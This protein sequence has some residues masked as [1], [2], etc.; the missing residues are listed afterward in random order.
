MRLAREFSSVDVTCLM[1]LTN[2]DTE[3]LRKVSLLVI[4]LPTLKFLEK[5]FPHAMRYFGKFVCLR[6]TRRE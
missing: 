1:S 4:V 6:I 3:I 5:A 2:Y